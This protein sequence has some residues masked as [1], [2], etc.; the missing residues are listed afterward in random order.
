[1]HGTAPGPKDSEKARL[2]CWMLGTLSSDQKFIKEAA[3]ATGWVPM[4]HV[5]QNL[6]PRAE[7]LALIFVAIW[8]IWLF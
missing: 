7:R 5:P 1:M 4:G 6:D 8:E 2:A 3:G